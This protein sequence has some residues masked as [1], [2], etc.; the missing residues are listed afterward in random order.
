MP[1][2][3]RRAPARDVPGASTA[4]LDRPNENPTAEPEEAR[5]DLWWE[6]DEA[7]LTEPEK[8]EPPEMSAE[9]RALQNILVDQFDGH[10]LDLPPLPIVAER[11]IRRLADS[12]YDIATLCN[13]IAE[14]QVIAAAV[15]RMANS[16]MYAGVEKITSLKPAVNRLGAS[17]IRTLMLH[18]S[19]RAASFSRRGADAQLSDMLWKRSLANAVITRGLARFTD[20][21]PDEAFLHGLL[22]DIG[23]VVVLREVQR[24]QAMLHYKIEFDAFEYFCAECHQ[25]LGEL[26]AQAWNL[27]ADLKSLI[28]DHHRP[29]APDD[30]LRRQRYVMQLAAMV[31]S[32]VGY[33]VPASYRLLE[34]EPMQAL[35]LLHRQGFRDFLLEL[36][37]HVELHVAS[38]A[39]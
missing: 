7:T 30:P 24:Q 16:A 5:N 23:S 15:I 6:L 19:L 36:P 18:Q 25:E 2:Q 34:T 22:I 10:E 33:G 29:P 35:Q 11:V 1:C 4:V 32:M 31:N 12:N 27:P 3:S 37:G 39:F 9:S 8:I 14:D 20:L 28:A 26:V 17:A 21:D 13:D 38:L